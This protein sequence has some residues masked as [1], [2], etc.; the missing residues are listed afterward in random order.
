MKVTSQIR[1]LTWR[2]P[3]AWPAKTWLRLIF[4]RFQQIRPQVV[5][6]AVQSVFSVVAPCQLRAALRNPVLTQPIHAASRDKRRCSISL[7]RCRLHTLSAHNA[8]APS[9]CG[10]LNFY[11][12]AV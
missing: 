4:R 6:I 1:S 8:P 7:T 3:T 10:L 5:T 2:T 11:E 12:R 9:F